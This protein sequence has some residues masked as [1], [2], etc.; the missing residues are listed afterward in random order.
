MSVC[1]GVDEGVV[2]FL[3]GRLPICPSTC[4]RSIEHTPF[5][6]H[7]LLLGLVYNRRFGRRQ[8]IA[9]SQQV[10]LLLA[11]LCS[12]ALVIIAKVNDRG[13]QLTFVTA[14]RHTV[15]HRDITMSNT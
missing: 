9:Q 13:L 8:N 11:D 12:I 1:G 10:L 14:F 5:A 7:S 4:R 3:S 15:P 6:S 2:K